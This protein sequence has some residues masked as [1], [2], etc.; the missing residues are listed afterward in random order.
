MTPSRAAGAIDWNANGVP[1]DTLAAQDINFNGFFNTDPNANPA[2]PLLNAGSNDWKFM[3]FNQVG[4]RA[5]RRRHLR[6][7][8]RETAG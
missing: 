2:P 5:Q 3:L 6:R 1:D 7:P 4:G 8:G